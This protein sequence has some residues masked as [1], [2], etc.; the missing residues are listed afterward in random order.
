LPLA[1]DA[2]KFN[3]KEEETSNTEARKPDAY[4]GDAVE[5]K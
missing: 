2:S 3:E 5:Q 1:F 4:M